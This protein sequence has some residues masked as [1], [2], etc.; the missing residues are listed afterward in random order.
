[1][2]VPVGLGL[3]AH[4]LNGVHHFGT[5]GKDRIAELGKHLPQGYAIAY[6]MDTSQFVK[7]SIQEVVETLLVAV[8]LVFVD[9]WDTARHGRNRH[10]DR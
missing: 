8:V 4:L 5:L 6:P 10:G 1:M 2:Q 9:A 3:T 7:L